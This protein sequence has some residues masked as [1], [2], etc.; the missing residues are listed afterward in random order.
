MI[1]S[2]VTLEVDDGKVKQDKVFSCSTWCF[3]F[4]FIAVPD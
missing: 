3:V 2:L 4:D 1:G